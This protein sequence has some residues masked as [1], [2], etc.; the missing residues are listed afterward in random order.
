MTSYG[1]VCTQA[2][3][4]ACNPGTW[5]KCMCMHIC[6]HRHARPH[7]YMCI[8]VQACM[9][10]DIDEY[11]YTERCPCIHTHLQTYTHMHMCVHAWKPLVQKAGPQNP[12]PSFLNRVSKSS[13][14]SVPWSVN[15]WV[16][17][18]SMICKPN[19]SHRRLRSFTN[20]SSKQVLTILKNGNKTIHTQKSVIC[21]HSTHERP[22]IHQLYWS[23]NSVFIGIRNMVF[24]SIFL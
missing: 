10:A 7:M 3:V 19:G 13:Q 6:A 11:I 17:T 18:R 12:K 4:H 1:Y 5:C 9:A 23:L 24:P 8:H 22:L 20:A 14:A 21:Y 15:V 2:Y 16:R